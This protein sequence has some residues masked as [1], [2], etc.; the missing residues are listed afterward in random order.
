MSMMISL[1]GMPIRATMLLAIVATLAAEHR[2][3]SQTG[4]DRAMRGTISGIVTDTGLTAIG[5]ANVSVV[6]LRLGVRSG[7]NGR[8]EFRNMPGGRYII[9]VAAFGYEPIT[10]T[11]EVVANDTLR[12]AV[13]L[14]RRT[15]SLDTVVATAASVVP[16]LADFEARRAS[17][18]G[19]FLSEA[20]IARRNSVASTE[21][22]R[23]FLSINVRPVVNG[24]QAPM[25]V[26]MSRRGGGSG[27]GRHGGGM[28]CEMLVILDG[29]PM[30][31]PFDLNTLPAPKELAGIELYSGDARIPLRFAGLDRGCG[32]IL[33]WTKHAS[34]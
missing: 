33:V 22:L 5:R 24:A 3:A 28:E 14:E 8:F 13:S 16:G 31:T 9:I 20:E 30:P 15:E 10:E 32:V 7:P 21:L 17:G 34:E 2:A 11:I 12:L 29:I 18:Q 6:G 25:Y 23:S 27:L 26:A 4:N 19:Q 1:V